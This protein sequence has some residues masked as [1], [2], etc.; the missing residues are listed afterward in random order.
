MTRKVFY[1]FH[2]VPD[3]QRAAQVRN[4]G[5]LEGNSVASDNEWESIT[6]GGDPAIAKWIDDQ[7]Y[8]R[9]CAVIL[10]GSATAGRKWINY[11]IEKAWTDGRGVVGIYIHAKGSCWVHGGD[12]I[13]SLL[14][15]QR[16]RLQ[17]EFDSAVL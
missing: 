8:G 16:Q 17:S 1:S 9:S 15:C 7:M 2:Y 12:G 4:M 13:Q 14:L 10:A 11:E 5:K 6:D 3:S